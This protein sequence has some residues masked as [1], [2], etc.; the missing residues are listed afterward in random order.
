MPV[1]ALL[2]LA[3]GG[4]AVEEVGAGGVHHLVAFSSGCSTTPTGSSRSAAPACS[5]ASAWWCRANE[6]RRDHRSTLILPAPASDG[7]PETVLELDDVT[8]DLRQRAAGGRA[9]RGQLQR[10]PRRAGR[11]RRPVRVGQVDAAAPDG[12]ARAAEL[13]RRSDHRPRR[14]RPRR[15][16]A[17]GA[18][19]DAD[20]LRLPAVLPRRARNRARERRRRPALRRRPVAR[21]ARARGRARSRAVGLAHRCGA[22]RRSSRAASASASRSRARWSGRPAIVLADEPTG[23]L[24][25]A[26]G[27]AILAL[28][29]ELHAAGATIVVITHDRDLAARPAA[30][31]RDARRPHR[32]RHRATPA[33]RRGE[34]S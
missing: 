24:D 2:A 12:H 13:G 21:A 5:P 8:Q 11:D 17:G 29:Q 15:P 1:D 30:P 22:G 20:R 14:R 23:N 9:R 33:V 28:L 19:R 34:R 32:R 18:A 31:D 26:T 7:S 10:P 6:R 4:Y 27:A 16:R 25:S 3:S